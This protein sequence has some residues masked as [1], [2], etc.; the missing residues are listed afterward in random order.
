MNNIYLIKSDSYYLLN[1]KIKELTNDIKD[2]T[3]V[4]LDEEEIGTIIN[5]ASYYG[6][7]NEKPYRT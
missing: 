1:S 5:D 2:I 3:K 7:F 4:D 6:L